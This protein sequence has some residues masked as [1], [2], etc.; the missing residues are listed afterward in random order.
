MQGLTPWLCVCLTATVQMVF[1][2]APVPVPMSSQGGLTYT[3]TFDDIANWGADFD[4]GTEATRWEGKSAAGS[5]T[6]PNGTYTTAATDSS[7][8]TGSTAGKQKGTG[9]IGQ[10]TK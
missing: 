3:A 1:A 2:A 8:A 10:W 7:W 4:S 6:I 5:G 9:N